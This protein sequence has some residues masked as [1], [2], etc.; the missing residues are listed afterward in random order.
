MGN[1][2]RLRCY[3]GRAS[4]KF[5]HCFRFKPSGNVAGIAALVAVNLGATDF[6]VHVVVRVAVN[7]EANPAGLD[8]AVQIGGKRPAQK[9]TGLF[10]RDAL[11]T[12]GVTRDA[13]GLAG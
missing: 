11:W 12:G 2:R 1:L 10:G 8:E 4:S 5:N 6:I 7:P 13:N 9:I 3:S